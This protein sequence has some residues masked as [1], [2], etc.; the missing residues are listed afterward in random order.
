MGSGEVVDLWAMAAELERQFAG[1]KQRLAERN[2]SKHDDAAADD[3]T[4]G[5]VGNGGGEEAE[6]EAEAEAGGSGGSGHDVRGRMYEAYVRR[7]DERLREGWSARM[8][9]KEAEVKALWAHLELGGR[10]GASGGGEK[11]PGGGGPTTDDGTAGDDEHVQMKTERND[12]DKRRSSDA[13]LAPKRISGKK[14][15]RTRS[16]SSSITTSR[17]RTDVGRRRALSQEP[18]PS[19]PHAAGDAGKDNR[20]RPAGSAAGTTTATPRLKT[21]LRRKNSVKGHGFAKP[22]G[23]KLP[24]SLPRRASSGGLEPLSRDVVPPIADAAA[25]VQSHS[26]EQAVHGGTP[27]VSPPRPFVVRGNSCGGTDAANA[28]TASPDSDCSEVVNAVADAEAKAKS[29]DIRKRSDEEVNASPDKLG[30]PN[31]EITSESDTEPSYVYINKDVVQEQ[32]MRLP[33]PLAASDAEPEFCVKTNEENA[34]EPTA[35]TDATAA[36]IATTNAEEAPA[37]ESS[38]EASFSGRSGRS[39]P[40]SARPSFSSRDQSIERLLEADAA[41]LRKKRAEKS[42][43][44]TPSSAGS[45]DSGT[46]RSPNGTVRGFK[47]FLSFGKKNRGREV[48]VIDC[49]SPSMPSLAD[50]DSASGRWQSA[51]SIKP[52]MG[53]SDAASHDT[54]QGYPVSPRAACSLQSLVAASPAKSELAEIVPQE[55]S[56]KGKYFCAAYN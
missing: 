50:D 28:R 1:Y 43:L 8:E 52:R 30:N 53:S 47:R 27:K 51:G 2:G 26:S 48:T 5:G 35:P 37:R 25:P 17:N 29:T 32:A 15:A 31:G 56:P 38:D 14:H 11:A 10:A 55:K 18:P 33:E 7:R 54:D 34:E 49:T 46:A 24:R 42:A 9:R 3:D 21:S 12:D 6:V 44:K 39:H 40:N 4:G 23:P 22:A 45:R 16:F 13:A 20:A 19:E 41:L 36:E